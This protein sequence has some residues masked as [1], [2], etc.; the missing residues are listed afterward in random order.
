MAEKDSRIKHNLTSSLIYQVV[1]ISLSFLLPRLYLENFGSEVNGVLSTIK[2]IFTYLLLLE[3]G[4]GLATTQA[5]Y[6]RI[7]EKDYKSASSVLSATHAYYIKTGIIYLILVLLIAVLYSFVINTSID[8]FELFFIIILTAIPA[9]FSYFVQAKYRILMEVD[10]RKYVINHSE[11]VLQ[12]VSNAAKILVLLL[13]D[14]LI[15][16]QL[17]YCIIYLAQLAFLYF[18]A[19]RRYRWLDLKAK[20]DFHAISQKNSVLVHQLSGMVFNNTDVI[21][22]SVLCDFRAVSIYAIYN[23]FFSQVQNFITNV[24]SSFTF[25]L[26][27]MF[28]TDREKFDK[29]FASYETCYVMVTYLIYTLMAVFLL[30]LIQIYTSGIND[31]QY[32]NV[33]LLLLFVVMNLLACAKLPANGIIEY[34]GHFEKTRSHA[35]WEMVINLTVSVVAILSMGIC[36]AI[37]GTIAALLY[38]GIVTIY[39]SNKKVLGRSQM[40]TYKILL[41]NS[42]VFAMV[43]AIFYVDTFSG[44]SFVQLLGNGVLHSVWIAGLYLLVN[45]MVNQSAFKTMLGLYR[46]M[47]KQ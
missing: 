11:T 28:H 45:F 12:I 15:L 41:S 23:I 42:A 44:N 14:S 47:K 39:Y 33:P 29:M 26:G 22:I 3:A 32:S 5:L 7:G 13:S 19:K 10:G 24:V 38:R 37:L 8:R 16:I 40:C 6:K 1:L 2:Q 9:L 36:G 34:A 43:M 46:E 4:V 18:Y 17:V 30:P 20:P 21:L 31:A 25:A 35:V 27:Q